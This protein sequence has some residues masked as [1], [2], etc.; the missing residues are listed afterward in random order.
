M[1]IVGLDFETANAQRNSACQ[2]GLVVL[3]DGREVDHYTSLIKPPGHFHPMN[4]SIH[5]IG[6]RHVVRAPSFAQ[7]WPEVLPRL[8]AGR[9]VFAHNAAFDR[10]VLLRSLEH[11]GIPAP[12]IPIECSVNLARTHLPTLPNHR[13]P[14]VCAALG[15]ALT[16]HHDALADARAAALVA[17]AMLRP[18]QAVP[19]APGTPAVAPVRRRKP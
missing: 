1:I 8:A 6:P 10:G 9:R 15:I 5:G 18:K 14:T 12:A 11:C 17:W 16:G 13:L 2:I 4:V 7:I 19:A 3:E